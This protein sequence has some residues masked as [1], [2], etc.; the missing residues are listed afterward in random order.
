MVEKQRQGIEKADAIRSSH[1]EQ[2]QYSA[3][4]SGD[5]GA[6]SQGVT[7][8]GLEPKSLQSLELN[9]VQSLET[10]IHR[11]LKSTFLQRLIKPAIGQTSHRPKGTK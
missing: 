11:D 2:S 4:P 10:K 5:H 7:H 8:K 9:T 3:T 1:G 6:H